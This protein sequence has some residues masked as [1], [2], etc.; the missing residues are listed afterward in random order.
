MKSVFIYFIKN[1]SIITLIA[2]FLQLI[3]MLFFNNL[4]IRFFS[5]PIIVFAFIFYILNFIKKLK[6]MI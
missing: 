4:D 6:N 5:I 3:V 1:I 2:I